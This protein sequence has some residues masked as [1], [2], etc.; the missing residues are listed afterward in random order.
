MNTV[1][2]GVNDFVNFTREHRDI[3]IQSSESFKEIKDQSLIDT[4][5]KYA[6]RFTFKNTLYVE[7]VNQL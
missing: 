5:G 3:Y 1:I 4:C 7:N 2:L 6:R